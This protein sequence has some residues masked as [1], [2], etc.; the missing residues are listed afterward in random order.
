MKQPSFILRIFS[1]LLAVVV[2]ITSTGFVWV[3]HTCSVKGHQVSFF[4]ADKKTCSACHKAVAKPIAKLVIQKTHCCSEQHHF[5][6][7]TFS[8]THSPLHLLFEK[9]VWFNH[10]VVNLPLVVLPTTT[11]TYCLFNA[12]APPILWEGKERL[13]FIQSFLI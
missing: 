3:E 5:E 7:A 6:K 4:K 8:A 2:F 9:A 1:F 11:Q 10:H 13:S 12:H